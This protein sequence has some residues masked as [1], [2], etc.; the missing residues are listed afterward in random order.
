MP[1]LRSAKLAPF[2]IGSMP[3]V[4]NEREAAL[5]FT[6]QEAEEFAFSAR[7]EMDW[8]NEH[9][10]DVLS[11]NHKSF[12]DLMKTPSKLRGKTPRTARKPLGEITS[13]NGGTIFDTTV[14][15]TLTSPE[16]P[17]I[18]H[19]NDAPDAPS[20]EPMHDSS[21]VKLDSVDV[22]VAEHSP[23][24]NVPS[25]PPSKPQTPTSS[26]REPVVVDGES[27]PPWIPSIRSSPIAAK[28]LDT[29]M[30]VDARPGLKPQP[31]SEH[32][33][34]F[35]PIVR[36]SSLNFAS[37]PAREPMATAKKSIRERIDMLGA[38]LTNGRQDPENEAS[39][40]LVA[41]L[42]SPKSKVPQPAVTAKSP[43]DESAPM[44]TPA[45]A[46]PSNDLAS[47]RDAIDREALRQPE[48]SSKDEDL[49][50]ELAQAVL[51]ELP[52]RSETSPVGEEA[53]MQPLSQ[54]KPVIKRLMKQ[55]KDHNARPPPRAICV[56]TASQ[57]EL[58]RP[59][60]LVAA[61]KKKE[62]EEREAQRK[63]DQ[64]RELEQKRAARQEEE[65]RLE[66]ER[67]AR[68]EEERR[69]ERERKA[70]EDEERRQARERAARQEEER[71]LAR[72]R[73]ARQE[74]ERRVAQDR[75]AREEERRLARERVAQAEEERRQAREKILRQEQERQQEIERERKAAIDAKKP[76]QKPMLQKRDVTGSKRPDGT[77]A[78]PTLPRTKPGNSLVQAMGQD[79]ASGAMA[80]RRGELGNN[81]A[82]SRPKPIT[83]IRA[84]QGELKR[85]V[86]PPL[87]T[88]N[89]PINPAAPAKRNLLRDGQD[90]QTYRAARAGPPT[91]QH[92]GQKGP[93]TFKEDNGE[94][95]PQM[96]PPLRR[97]NTSRPPLK[98]VFNEAMEE[99]PAPQAG[100]PAVPSHQPQ[101]QQENW[102]RRKTSQETEE[103][104]PMRAPMP[105]PMRPSNMR[106]DVL[107][108]N[109]IFAPLPSNYTN[110]GAPLPSQHQPTISAVS[111]QTISHTYPDGSEIELPDIATDSEGDDYSDSSAQKSKKDFVVPDW[112]NSPNLRQ[113]LEDQQ[114]VEPETVFGPMAPLHMEEIF[115]NKDRHHRFR[116]RTSS[117]NWSGADRLTQEEIRRDMAARERLRREGGWTF[118]L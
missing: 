74:E 52:S 99:A 94:A 31:P 108:K 118:A 40:D 100:A 61:E 47:D 7:N 85:E 73:A 80:S 50:P 21:V 24:P 38:R 69:V 17:A 18:H 107:N 82:V 32:S 49:L 55:P 42:K 103:E 22:P 115:K 2:S 110:N 66:R 25:A 37:L 6:E 78:A 26:P 79:K 113:T 3:W 77:A 4:S 30:E 72:E 90:D 23:S 105:P 45:L 101:Q 44:E 83:G 57:R 16:K 86:N 48:S 96:A 29:E 114:L 76:S 60:A 46:E 15:K 56:G 112:A 36:K 75:A 34:P 71:R 14:P 88:Y 81:K 104:F 12:A 11:H 33:S 39:H 1:A 19:D 8:L 58:T 87:A 41:R 35:Q 70:R 117:A 54:P 65:R 98:R 27:S 68:Q 9:M 111:A 59:K 106:K 89:R 92:D 53:T 91:F 84:P 102:K 95:R 93:K 13:F 62:Q 43:E 97:S 116:P 64:K 20:P 5:Q 63:L 51:S 109:S 28:S 67:A 10:A